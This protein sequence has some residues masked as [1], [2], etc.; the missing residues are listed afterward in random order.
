VVADVRDAEMREIARPPRPSST[1]G[2]WVRDEVHLALEMVALAGFVIARPVLASFGDAPEVFIAEAARPVD[3]VVFAVLVAAGPLPVALAGGTVLRFGGPRLRLGA[4]LAGVGVLAGLATWQTVAVVT[5]LPLAWSAAAGAVGGATVGVWRARGSGMASFL[6]YGAVAAVVFL[7]Q[8]LFMSPSSSLIWQGGAGADAGVAAAI[9]RSVGADAPP[10]VMVVL[11]ELPTATLLDGTGHIDA[12]LFPN[13]ARLAADGTWYRN[14]TTV[15]G[16]TPQ[17]LSAVLTGRYPDPRAAPTAATSPDNLFTLL[18][19]S[20]ELHVSEQLTAFCPPTLCEDAVSSRSQ[21]PALV[22]DGVGLW[23]RYMARGG[24]AGI[25]TRSED[26]LVQLEEW[27][28]AQDFAGGGP[29]GLH[30]VHTVLPHSSWE[31]LPDGTRYGTDPHPTG[32]RADQVWTDRGTLVGRQRHVL[33][34]QAVDRALGRLVEKLEA[35]GAYDDALVVVTAD[36]GGAFVPNEPRRA[37][38]EAQFDEIAWTPLVVKAPGQRAGS[39]SDENVQSID[40]LP[41]VLEI[42]GVEGPPPVDGR[43]IS[44]DA[45]AGEEKWLMPYE[46]M[47]LERSGEHGRV[48][49][50]AEEGLRRVLA[51]DPV[52]GTGPAAVWQLVPRRPLVGRS[53]ADLRLGDPAGATVEAGFADGF[54]DLE[55]D[56]PMRLQID[57]TATVEPGT[58]V[59]V[60]VNGVVSGSTLAEGGDGDVAHVQ[61]MVE[62]GALKAGANDVRLFT[63]EGE[64][65][66]DVLREIGPGR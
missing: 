24:A 17:A 53:L 50:D 48:R 58:P 29:P 34:T 19:S 47:T 31:Y 1:L 4:H 44:G 60:A 46:K 59:V 41:T 18:A 13:V 22:A 20:Y 61:V 45:P 43:A 27:I 35:A 42:I 38:T 64:P 40:I 36:H 11:D 9:G 14:H 2:A 32:A 49:L 63:V 26:R 7:G 65:G 39:V 21:V 37:A 12:D 56:A 28:A 15:A 66:E 33:Q 5:P 51:A 23:G 10:I 57:T 52:A 3:I 8:F 55:L 25:P 6:R 62:P 16:A 54:D 30:F